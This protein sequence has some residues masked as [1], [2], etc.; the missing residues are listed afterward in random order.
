[1][2][3]PTTIEPTA[4]QLA[5]I[6]G[7]EDRARSA[8]LELQEVQRA[9]D[10]LVADGVAAAERMDV[11][12]PLERLASDVA[13]LHGLRIVRGLD[14]FYDWWFYRLRMFE[15]IGTFALDVDSDTGRVRQLAAVDQAIASAD[16]DVVRVL[17][18][19][20]AARR[21]DTPAVDV[22][23]VVGAMTIDALTNRGEA[24]LTKLIE[25]GWRP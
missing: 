3:V 2:S 5:V 11:S 14:A 25:S 21:L 9:L 13:D 24:A 23:E 15:S 4:E 17:N 18:E 10:R 6:G 20:S 7:L 12:S 19:L 1:M 22:L 16:P 8:Q